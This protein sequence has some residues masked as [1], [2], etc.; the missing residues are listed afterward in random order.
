MGLSETGTGNNTL[1]AVNAPDPYLHT[2]FEVSDK[3]LKRVFSEDVLNKFKADCFENIRGDRDRT[4][5]EYVK[6]Y[7]ALVKKEYQSEYTG[8]NPSLNESIFP[9]PVFRKY[10]GVIALIF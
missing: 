2:I 5:A 8:A 7:Y 1:H 6:S 9:T 3:Y 4:I 10:C